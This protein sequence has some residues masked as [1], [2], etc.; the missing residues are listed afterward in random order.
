M[1]IQIS[2]YRSYK[3]SGL[4]KQ[5]F[6]LI[7]CQLKIFPI[8]ASL[9]ELECLVERTPHGIGKETVFH[10]MFIEVGQHAAMLRRCI[11]LIDQ[12]GQ[13]GVEHSIINAID[14]R[15]KAFPASE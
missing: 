5:P 3:L 2:S 1:L 15:A 12:K 10:E 6:H 13:D 4:I 9:P 14:H 8:I 11:G 7:F